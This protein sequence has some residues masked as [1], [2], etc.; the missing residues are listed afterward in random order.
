[1]VTD[2]QVVLR[3]WRKR[4]STLLQGNDDNNTAFRDV[5]PNPIDN[6][7]VEVPPP[8]NK[9]VK[10][11]NMRLK[12]NKAAIKRIVLDWVQLAGRAHAPAYLQNMTRGKNG[13]RL[14]PQCPL[15]CSEAGLLRETLGYAPTTGV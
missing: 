5:V 9:K 14:E 7:G 6:D 11:A 10:V 12:N 13:Q 15:S 8:R 2:P 3:L 4:F 1:M